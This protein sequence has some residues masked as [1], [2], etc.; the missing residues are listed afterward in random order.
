[1]SIFRLNRASCSRHAIYIGIVLAGSALFAVG[2]AAPVPPPSDA[3]ELKK[4]LDTARDKTKLES[5]STGAFHLHATF[6]TFD[7]NGKPDGSG[8]LAIWWDGHERVKRIVTYRGLTQTLIKAHG[9]FTSS[10]PFRSSLSERYLL[11]ALLN[12]VPHLPS[13]PKIALE[14]KPT[15]LGGL[16]AGCII[17]T[18]Q[19]M[20][21]GGKVLRDPTPAGGAHAYC[22][23]L[24]DSTLRLAKAPPD[25]TITYNG[26]EPFGDK[27]V[28]H[29]ISITEEK[30]VRAKLEIDSM[31]PWDPVDSDFIPQTSALHTPSIED[32]PA[33]V[34]EGMVISKVPPVYPEIERVKRASGTVIVSAIISRDG[35]VADA[36]A[37]SSPSAG[38]SQAAITAVKQWRYRPYLLDGQPVEVMTNVFVNFVAH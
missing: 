6:E 38:F 1:M 19:P 23:T 36:E 3:T 12:P 18:P 2:R 27:S 10:E 16:P 33:G 26:L 9:S 21:V 34:A 31:A 20:V 24:E 5:P 25:K 28:A 4:L 7:K 32:V 29:R 35:A 30:T 11:D 8:E 17:A 14:Y 22:L 15:T 37:A 13:Q